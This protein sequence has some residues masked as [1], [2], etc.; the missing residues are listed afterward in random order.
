[1]VVMVESLSYVLLY[2]CNPMDCSP[3]GSSVQGIPQARIL[4]WVTISFSRGSSQSRG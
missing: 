3:S 1:M 2:S 4:K